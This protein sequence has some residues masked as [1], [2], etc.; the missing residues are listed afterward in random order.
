MKKIISSLLMMACLLAF[1]STPAAAGDKQRHRWEG[2]AIGVG[3]ALLGHAVLDS[4]RDRDCDWDRGRGRDWDRTCR[5]ERV[6]VYK[7]DGRHPPAPMPRYSRGHWEM[8]KV[9]VPPVSE[10]VWN[11]GHYSR[12]GHWVSGHWVTVERESG[13]WTKERVW[14]SRR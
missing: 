11:P 3:A 10:R 13:Y 8:R 9:W 1:V 2:V 12:H 7:H 14:V 5:P 6:R 4:Y